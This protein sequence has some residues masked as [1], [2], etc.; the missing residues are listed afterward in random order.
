VGVAL[1]KQNLLLRAKL[2]HSRNQPDF[3]RKN[4]INTFLVFG[5][6]GK[7][8]GNAGFD[9]TRVTGWYLHDHR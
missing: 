9:N 1:A 2:R 6:K 8:A 3:S 5:F 4:I 7:I